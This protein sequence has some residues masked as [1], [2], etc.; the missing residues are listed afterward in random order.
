MFMLRGL[1]AAIYDGPTSEPTAAD[2]IG[3]MQ[4]MI[5]RALAKLQVTTRISVTK[6][7]DAATLAGLVLI[8]NRSTAFPIGSAPKFTASY[9]SSRVAEI[10]SALQRYLNTT[11]TGGAVSTFPGGGGIYTPPLL[12]TTGGGDYVPP[13]LPATQPTLPPP[14]P[15]PLQPPPQPL[16]TTSG[17]PT[18]QPPGPG[19]ANAPSAPYAPAQAY[20][21]PKL[22]KLA[23]FALGVSV[24]A[25]TGALVARRRR[26]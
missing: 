15:S 17:Q 5:N 24:V 25:L 20:P 26:G 14:P 16:P 7:I 21:A 8:A 10:V 23:L 9:V 13:P 6:R 4:L 2:E 11:S 12:P 22:G 1:G 19:P 3:T 18:A